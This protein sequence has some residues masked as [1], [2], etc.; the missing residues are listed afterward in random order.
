VIGRRRDL[1]TRPAGLERDL[2]LSTDGFPAMDHTD[3][4]QRLLGASCLPAMI[5][6]RSTT[7]LAEA[8]SN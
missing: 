6:N 5:C 7:L 4:N 3:L 2:K 8:S 1:P